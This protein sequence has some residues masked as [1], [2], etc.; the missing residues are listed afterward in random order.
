[1]ST[2]RSVD[3]IVVFHKGRVVETG[4]HDELMEKD[5]VYARLYR[6]QFAV[7]QMETRAAPAALPSKDALPRPPPSDPASHSP[8]VS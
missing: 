6:F 4:T 8:A 3:R 5:G 2:I 7:E 1:M